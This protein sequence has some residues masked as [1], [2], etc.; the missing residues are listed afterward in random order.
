MPRGASLT[1]WFA[2]AAATGLPGVAEARRDRERTD[3]PPEKVAER[4]E[5][6]ADA[7]QGEATEEWAAI[8]PTVDAGGAP[9]Q[10][11]LEAFI[12]EYDFA[13]VGGRGRWVLRVP[14]PEVALALARLDQENAREISLAFVDALGR[15]ERD[16][17]EDLLGYP[18]THG[19]TS[20][21]REDWADVISNELDFLEEA[22]AFDQRIHGSYVVPVRLPDGRC[23]VG[24]YDRW[25]KAIERRT[26]L[27]LY[28]PDHICDDLAQNWEREV[29]DALLRNRRCWGIDPAVNEGR[30]RPEFTAVVVDTSI[31]FGWY[32]PVR[33]HGDSIVW[34]R[35]DDDG[36]R[37]I[38]IAMAH[39]RL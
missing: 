38:G 12:D 1:L 21:C 26:A 23:L 3:G 8:A 28:R 5:A 35:R 33:Y 17:L 31:R 9:A 27:D 29:E 19:R 18:F 6:L 2:L 20:L 36:W 39:H 4:L 11:A 16:E 24:D 13:Q 14:V 25:M 37:V 10:A 7:L 32:V 34:L 22:H 30:S 15:G